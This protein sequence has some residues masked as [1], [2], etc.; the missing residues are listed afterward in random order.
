MFPETFLRAVPRFYPSVRRAKPGFSHQHCTQK[1]GQG[2]RKA[3]QM[4]KVFSSCCRWS[5]ELWKGSLGA[6]DRSRRLGAEG[7][8]GGLCPGRRK[9]REPAA[10]QHLH[11]SGNRDGRAGARGGQSQAAAVSGLQ[12]ALIP[13]GRAV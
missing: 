6:A 4:R 7:G 2:R 8:A 1:V 12:G 11:G 3:G 5:P 10:L 9:A 13:V